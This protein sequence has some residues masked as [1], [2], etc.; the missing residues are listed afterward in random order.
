LEVHAKEVQ[1]AIEKSNLKLL[2]AVS[3]SS[4]RLLKRRVDK[5]EVVTSSD[6]VENFDDESDTRTTFD[7]EIKDGSPIPQDCMASEAKTF[8]KVILN[9]IKELI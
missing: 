1:V 5:E 9:Q 3:A 8:E 6:E 2:A 7:Q 4:P